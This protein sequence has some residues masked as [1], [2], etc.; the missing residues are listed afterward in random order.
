MVQRKDD[1]VKDA[2]VYD[3]YRFEYTY[4]LVNGHRGVHHITII[5]PM[6]EGY[7]Y[8]LAVGHTN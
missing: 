1:F 7:T 8:Q 6:C 5:K 3:V 2:Y 4:D